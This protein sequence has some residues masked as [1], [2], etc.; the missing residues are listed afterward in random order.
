M[1]SSDNSRIV[2]TEGAAESHRTKVVIMNLDGSSRKVI[3]A[4]QTFGAIPRFSPSNLKLAY[5]GWGTD[6]SGN[7]T[8]PQIMVLDMLT[9]ATKAITDTR[10]ESWRPVF[11]PDE[12]SIVYISKDNAQC[13]VFSYDLNT[14]TEIRLT[15]TLTCPVFFGPPEA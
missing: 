15:T 5:A 14:G 4:G 8:N 10:R 13:D 9:G 11:A 1:L 3:T 12:S 6:S 2:F 7:L